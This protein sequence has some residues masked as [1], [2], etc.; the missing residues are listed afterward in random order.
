MKKPIKLLSSLVFSL[1]SV[2]CVQA[3]SLEWQNLT[4]RAEALYQKGQYDQGVLLA[5]EALDVAEK[6]RVPLIAAIAVS[7]TNLAMM[8]EAQGR[9]VQAEPLYERSLTIMEKDLGPD[10]PVVAASLLRLAALYRTQARYVQAEPLY[11]RS[12]AIREKAF[13]PDHVNVATGLSG[14]AVLYY[15]QGRYAQA[16][17]LYK[18]SLAIRE[19]AFGPDNSEVAANVNDLAAVYQAQGGYAQAETLYMRS[20]AIWEKILGPD[21][22]SVA[23]SL[24]N[25]AA[26]YSIQGQYAR[27]EPLLKRSLAIRYKTR[28]QDH[29]EVATSL[30]NLAVLY[31][32]LGQY[33]QAEPLLKRSLA[34]R[35]KVF[36]PDHPD[37]AAN[38]NNL[39]SLYDSQ[40]RYAEAEPLYKSALAVKERVFGSDHDDVALTLNNLAVLYNKQHLHAQAEPLLK[41]SLAIWE[42]A[43]GSD[44]PLVAKNLNNLALLYQDQGQYEQAEPLLKRSLAIF[45]NALGRDHPDVA[46]SLNNIAISSWMH[47]DIVRAVGLFRRSTSI[48]EHH[49]RLLLAKGSEYEKRAYIATIGWDTHRTISLHLATG[50]YAPDAARLALT[51]ILQRKG[52]ILDALT[53][54]YSE[55][56]RRLSP[57]NGALLNQLS[58]VNRQRAEL[59]VVA[60]H[61]QLTMAPEEYRSRMTKLEEEAQVLEGKISVSS[62][63]FRAQTEF[64]TPE[65]VQQAIPDDAA[66]VEFAVYRPFN[67]KGKTYQ[68]SWGPPRYIAYVLR[69]Q[70]DPMSVDLGEATAIERMVEDFR[71]GLANP[72][73]VY[74]TRVARELDKQVM[75][76]VRKLL[77]KTRTVLL[78]PDGALNLVPFG[79]LADENNQYLIERYLFTYL[80]SGRDLLRLQAKA[81]SRQQGTIVADVDYGLFEN[82]AETTRAQQD[83]ASRR[84]IARPGKEFTRL[85]N[86]AAEAQAIAGILPKGVKVLTGKQATESAL[87]Q[88]NGPQILHVATHGFFLTALQEELVDNRNFH[89]L[90]DGMHWARRMENPLLRSGLALADANQLQSGTEDGMLTALEAASLDLWG[91]KLVVLSACETGVG[92]VHTGEGVFGL[93]RAL[94]IAGSESQVMSLWKVDDLATKDLMVDYYRHLISNMSRPEA[95]RQAQLAMLSKENYSHPNYWASFIPSGDW[96]ELESK[97][98][99]AQN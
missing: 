71:Q 51:T 55:L 95:L 69:R 53:D 98:Q 10:D 34:I 24:N 37:V 63:E 97:M 70:G 72:R 62:A 68:E 93:R 18:R 87:K 75:L 82:V 14:L 16:E 7:L 56:R 9:Y 20:L 84:P 61:D 5:K 43:L 90:N 32:A 12:L 26:L 96:T 65:R 40:G 30:N 58:S 54:S 77:G 3:Q 52:R 29:P 44:H 27:A 60:R 11:K 59:Y 47:G 4:A 41:R 89:S 67:P 73:S 6:E 86:T 45:E 15:A 57:E 22:D 31:E 64:I 38:L 35:E 94:V 80:S 79:A 28:G 81:Q 92:E 2:T 48:R 91:T 33:V 1:V 74:V 17:P 66:L 19:K 50:V 99:P 42:K 76:P 88:L 23:S 21:G 78:S 39:A 25:L 46:T 36:G 8:Y 83:P 13:G 49:L 85:R